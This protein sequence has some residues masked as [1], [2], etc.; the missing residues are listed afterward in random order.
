MTHILID[1]PIDP[2]RIASE[3]SDA[4][5]DSESGGHSVFIGQVRNDSVEGK[6]VEAIEYSAYPAMADS[7]ADRI[8][9]ELHS[10]FPDLRKIV[11]LHSTGIVKAGEISLFVMASAGHRAQAIEACREAVERIKERLPVWKK[12]LFSDE[13]FRWKDNSK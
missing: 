8:A 7:E 1:G 2:G 5:Q 9:L 12:E 3:I 11:I 6:P 4:G 13:S 10:I